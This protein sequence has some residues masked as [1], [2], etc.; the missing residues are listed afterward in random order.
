MSL[1]W[2]NLPVK[3]TTS[4][5]LA[6][7]GSAHITCFFQSGWVRVLQ[8]CPLGG[9][10]LPA[11]C[12]PLGSMPLPGLQWWVQG[13][14][15]THWLFCQAKWERGPCS[16]SIHPA[17][18]VNLASCQQPS[19]CKAGLSIRSWQWGTKLGTPLLPPIPAVFAT[20][21]APGCF[22]AKKCLFQN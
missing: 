7:T 10:V 11:L 1:R 15:K 4:Y 16:F 21:L 14:N 13:A 6:C 8:L 22:R 3:E 18:G 17:G 9:W 12:I 19:L 20:S 2:R 5:S